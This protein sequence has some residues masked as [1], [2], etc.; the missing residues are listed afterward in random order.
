MAKSAF[1]LDADQYTQH[2]QPIKDWL[3]QSAWHASKRLNKPFDHCYAHL[4]KKLKNGEID[5]KTWEK[6]PN[7]VAWVIYA[8]VDQEGVSFDLPTLKR[9]LRG[10][11][12]EAEIEESLN[13]LLASGELSRDEKTGESDSPVFLRLK[14]VVQTG[15][16]FPACKKHI[17][18]SR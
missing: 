6:I 7:W 4:E 3:T 8:M 16:A 13:G 11:A 2:L 17:T 15:L 18:I 12:S 14:I 1:L 10:N 5:R 9:L